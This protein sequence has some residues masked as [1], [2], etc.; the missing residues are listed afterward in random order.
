M[1][2]KSLEKAKSL[3]DDAVSL[4]N[5]KRQSFLINYTTQAL[6]QLFGKEMNVETSNEQTEAY[7]SEIR[8]LAQDSLQQRLTKLLEINHWFRVCRLTR[9]ETPNKDLVLHAVC[10]SKIHDHF[11]NK[12][13]N[14][15]EKNKLAYYYVY[16][17]RP[18]WA[19]ELLWPDFQNQVNNPEGFTILAK[20]LYTNYQDTQDTSYF[21]FL[22]EL[23]R[24][25]GNESWCAMFVGPCNISFQV[26]D[27][28]AFRN[29][30]CEKCAHYLNY[31]KKP[32][33][34][35]QK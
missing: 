18:D 28:E 10:L 6:I 19:M 24:R 12:A 35:P 33:E 11:T 15:A 4:Y 31:A 23:H 30:Y 7:I 5:N 9:E 16:H 14:Q 29:F 20:I 2:F 1:A 22:K 32:F 17:S 13:L 21:E 34:E 26:L 3:Y 25:I 27:Y 8:N